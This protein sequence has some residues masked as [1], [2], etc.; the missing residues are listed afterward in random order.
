MK[1][2]SLNANIS[3]SKIRTKAFLFFH[4]QKWFSH[5]NWKCKQ[6]N[7][8]WLLCKVNRFSLLSTQFN[9]HFYASIYQGRTRIMTNRA[10][11][12][13]AL[14]CKYLLKSLFWLSFFEIWAL[15]R[16]RK[17]LILLD[18]KNNN[19]QQ[20]QQQ[21]TTKREMKYKF[22]FCRTLQIF[23]T[24]IKFLLRALLI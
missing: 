11:L 24:R 9:I 2:L 20:Q 12:I 17:T 5:R 22:W 18:T 7:K 15:L 19:K 16:V 21:Q 8:A 10:A 4:P 14:I 6:L 23:L 3:K 13:S 1:F